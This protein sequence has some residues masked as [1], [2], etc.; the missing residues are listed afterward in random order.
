[1][2]RRRYRL[3]QKFG[4]GHLTTLTYDTQHHRRAQNTCTPA[5]DRISHIDAGSINRAYR[6]LLYQRFLL[7]RKYSNPSMASSTQ[8][9]K[10]TLNKA[11]PRNQIHRLCTR[12]PINT[13]CVWLLHPSS[14]S[15][16]RSDPLTFRDVMAN[17]GISC[18]E[19]EMDL[20]EGVQVYIFRD[21][22]VT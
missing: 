16:A 1:M 18:S 13:V 11:F 8:V 2:T 15:S 19:P 21:T 12:T 10:I 22:Y 6:E 20:R 14:P 4:L 3:C 5:W 17:F 7:G 9:L